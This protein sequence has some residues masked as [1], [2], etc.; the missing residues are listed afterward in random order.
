MGCKHSLKMVFENPAGPPGYCFY[1]VVLP[2]F[3]FFCFFFFSSVFV[4]SPFFCFWFFRLGFLCIF[5]CFGVFCFFL[6]FCFPLLAF[7]FFV[8]SFSSLFFSFL[9]SF[10]CIFLWWSFLFVS[11]LR[12]LFFFPL[13]S[14]FL[15]CFLSP[16]LLDTP[17]S[18]RSPSPVRWWSFLLIL[19]VFR[20]LSFFPFHF[21]FLL[22]LVVSVRLCSSSP[23]LSSL[24]L[25]PSVVFPAPGPCFFR[26]ATE[27]GEQREGGG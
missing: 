3:F 2:L 1:C 23:F 13:P 18:S 5:F 4:F 7:C 27:H 9:P 25:S 15:V 24:S 22:S 21:S 20:L 17:S 16:S 26:G 10:V 8:V 12:L 11:A 14:P 19:P 6:L